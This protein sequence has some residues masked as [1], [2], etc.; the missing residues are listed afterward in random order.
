MILP[1]LANRLV[2]ILAVDVLYGP[3][4]LAGRGFLTFYKDR[5]RIC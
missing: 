3:T 1:S 2:S 4:I 5:K